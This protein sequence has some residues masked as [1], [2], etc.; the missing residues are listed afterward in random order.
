[1]RQY[2]VA[3]IQRERSEGPHKNIHI[4]DP[5]Y[6]EEKKKHGRCGNTRIVRIKS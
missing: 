2:N 3:S 6:L 5:V 4:Y 1:M